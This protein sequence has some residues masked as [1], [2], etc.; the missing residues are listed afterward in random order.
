MSPAEKSRPSTAILPDVALSRRLTMLSRVVSRRPDH[1]RERPPLERSV[2]A[3]EDLG[4]NDV[5]EP[6]DEALDD[7][8]VSHS[9]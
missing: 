4:R 7:D 3:V 9:G 5:P 2:E 1:R 8:D 6:L